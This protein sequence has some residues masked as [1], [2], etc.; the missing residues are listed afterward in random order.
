MNQVLQRTIL[1]E[2][3]QYQQL[4]LQIHTDWTRDVLGVEGHGYANAIETLRFCRSIRRRRRLKTPTQLPLSEISKL[5]EWISSPQSSMLV[6]QG[7]GIRAS[8]MD[9]AID[10]IDAIRRNKK[11]LAIWALP[12]NFDTA[13]PP[14][15]SA[16]MQTLVL[17]MLDAQPGGLGG[18]VNPALLQQ[19]KGQIPISQWVSILEECAS[20]FESVFIIID[21]S[22]LEL[23]M[24]NEQYQAHQEAGQVVEELQRLVDQRTRGGLKVLIASV[25]LGVNWL[26]SAPVTKG[27]MHVF[28]D[29]GIPQEKRMWGPRSRALAIRQERFTTSRLGMQE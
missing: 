28:T 1:E 23:S 12:R 18:G 6:A 21:A 17:Q 2:R 27:I 10:F 4:Y 11:V 7:R 19:M 29:R 5:R 25:P 8:S 9:F 26:V 22:L 14:S 13:P 15:L 16:I 24:R 3:R 20:R